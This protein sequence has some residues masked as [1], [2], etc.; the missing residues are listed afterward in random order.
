[1][2]PLVA[3]AK[4]IATSPKGK[5]HWALVA[6]LYSAGL[7]RAEAAALDTED[8]DLEA[9]KVRVVGKGSYEPRWLPMSRAAGEA[10][11]AWLA[12]RPEGSPALFVRLDFAAADPARLTDDG[13]HHVIA[14]MGR[15]AG[16]GRP[17]APH[18][19]RHAS[20]T[21]LAERTGGNM[22]LIQEFSRHARVETVGVYVR[23]AR[24]AAAGLAELLGEDP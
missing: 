8:V 17:L 22:P 20:I 13:I 1:M 2:A 23:N 7:R 18:K 12:V 21:R 3:H 5:R 14:T 4:A 6:L 9:R 10:L 15:L 16:L 19:L 11:A 24:D